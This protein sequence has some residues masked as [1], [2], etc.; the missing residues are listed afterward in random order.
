[1]REPRWLARV[2]LVAVLALVGAACAEE[3]PPGGGGQQGVD[4]A[5][6]EFGCVEVG[7]D[8]PIKIAALQTLTGDAA[9][10]GQ[11]QVY[12]LRLAIDYLDGSFDGTPGQILGHDVELVEEDEQC[13]AEGGQAGA[14]RLAADPK[15]VAVFGTTC[16]S[17][18]LGVADT[19]LGEQGILL[20]SGSNTNPNLTA[21][22]V[23]NPFYARTAHN[24][25]IQ[26][27]VVAEFVY[28]ELGARKAATINDESPYAD[29]L[30]AVFRAVFEALGGE[31]TG[32][33]K[34]QS[35]DTEF[36]PVLTRLAEGR[37]DVLYY[38]DFP[39][40][41]GLV[42][43]QARDMPA[44][45]DAILVGSDGCASKDALDLAGDAAEGWYRSGPDTTGFQ[46]G[47]FYQNEFLPAYLDQFGVDAALSVFHAHI[48]DA[49]NI[50]KEALEKVAIE[51]DDGSLTIPRM[52]LRDA[53]FQTSGYQGLT[54]TITCTELGDCAT[55]VVIAIFQ[56]PG[57]PELDPKAEP[58]YTDTKS[59]QEVAEQYG[60]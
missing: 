3:A 42:T 37:P 10:L 53:L 33:E 22:G 46:G 16:S 38:P 6:V 47:D 24:D 55:D 44:F 1:M 58:V 40:V 21:E 31:I 14:T 56:A 25:K 15:L 8:E 59:L 5:T 60:V 43:A 18:A 51:N 48:Y 7:A 50:W 32:F 49:F 52:A 54:G 30:A 20:I 19:I 39:Q 34:V 17:A 28:N 13:T 4:C 11:D 36:G 26:G 2:A 29:A 45:A 27:A 9:A 23:H 57:W 35:T 41:C 12:G